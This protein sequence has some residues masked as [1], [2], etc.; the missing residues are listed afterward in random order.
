MIVALGA[1]LFDGAS[2]L[3]TRRRLQNVGDA[4]SLAGANVL[5]TIGTA[6]VCSTVA[7]SPPGAPRQDIV[8][9]VMASL[10][11]NWPAIT[12]S[13]VTITVPG[14]LGEPGGPGRPSAEAVGDASSAGRSA[15]AAPSVRHDIDGGQRPVDG[16]DL[17]GRPPRPVEQ[18][19]GRNARRGCPSRS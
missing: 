16:F 8:D 19:A 9:A 5:Q 14:R 13:D 18:L 1:L 2:A 6:H 11:T 10:A 7:D 15:W 17:L 4:A 12:A 3:V